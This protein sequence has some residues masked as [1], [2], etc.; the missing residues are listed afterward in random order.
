[1]SCLAFVVPICFTCSPSSYRLHQAGW[2]RLDDMSH[3]RCN[4]KLGGCSVQQLPAIR[5]GACQRQ[6]RHHLGTYIWTHLHATQRHTSGYCLHCNSSL[7]VC[8]IACRLVHECAP[9][10]GSSS[11][12]QP[13]LATACC[14][15]HTQDSLLCLQARSLPRRGL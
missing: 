10:S 5:L 1:M 7:T 13:L 11:Q 15:T 2:A 9:I 3:C 8:C 14:S 4:Q 6:G 12:W